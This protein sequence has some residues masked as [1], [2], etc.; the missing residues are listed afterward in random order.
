MKTEE[1]KAALDGLSKLVWGR[2]LSESLDAGICVICGNP[3]GE[4]KDK[5][6]EVE[7]T[8]TGMCQACQDNFYDSLEE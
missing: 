6:C 3:K 5:M 4:F 7:Y 8:L 2:S 1:I